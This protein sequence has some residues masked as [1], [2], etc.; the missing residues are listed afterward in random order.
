MRPDRMIRLRIWLWSSWSRRF[1]TRT[2][3]NRFREAGMIGCPQ[4]PPC[5]Y[6]QCRCALTVIQLEQHFG[7]QQGA[8][9]RIRS[10]NLTIGAYVGDGLFIGIREKF[11]SRYLD[12]EGF[13]GPGYI[14][15]GYYL[16]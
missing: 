11:G 10:R 13:N 2:L 1:R 15:L 9:Y 6:P 7:L 5:K 4:E 8:V 12:T 3:E 14:R 16:P